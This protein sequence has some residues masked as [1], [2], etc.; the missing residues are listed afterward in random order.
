MLGFAVSVIE[1]DDCCGVDALARAAELVRGRELVGFLLMVLMLLLGAPVSLLLYL[2]ARE[3]D[4]GVVV[5]VVVGIVG[6]ALAC[7]VKVFAFMA[8]TV[9]YHECRD[10]HGEKP[11]GREMY[12]LLSNTVRGANPSP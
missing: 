5:R 7:L 10:Y 3:D 4:Q 6:A 12:R 9:F 8:F 1:E 11:E 2:N